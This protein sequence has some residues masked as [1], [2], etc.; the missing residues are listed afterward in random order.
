MSSSQG[1]VRENKTVWRV[2][3]AYPGRGGIGIWDAYPSYEKAL[4]AFHEARMEDADKL[5]ASVELF[6]EEERGKPR[7]LKKW[8]R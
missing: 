2:F 5:F 4:T 6:E 1:P 3:C 8:T 7:S